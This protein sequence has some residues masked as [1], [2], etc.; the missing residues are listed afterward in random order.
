M[1]R[2]LRSQLGV[3]VAAALGLLTAI[4]ALSVMYQQWQGDELELSDDVAL[5]SFLL[6][7]ADSTDQQPVAIESDAQFALFFDENG[8]VLNTFGDVDGELELVLLDEVWSFTNV[9]DT[10]VGLEFDDEEGSW[11][12]S[13]VQCVDA[14]VCDTA[15]V[16]ARRAA[17]LAFWTKRLAWFILPVLAAIT[18]G[19][20][21]TRWLVGRSLKPVESMRQELDLI[22]ESDLERRVP[23]PQTTDEL[24]RLGS[25]MNQ[26][27]DR[28]ASS[29]DANQRFVA[30]AAHEL[31]SPITGVKAALEIEA[32][33][34]VRPD[35]DAEPSLLDDSVNELD[36]ASRLIDDLLVLAKRQGGAP[37]RTD[38]DLDDLVRA[39]VNM[40]EARHDGLTITKHIQPSRISADADAI[41]RIITN[42]LENAARYGDGTIDVSLDTD[43]QAGVVRLTVD[44]NGPGI[45]PEQQ[46]LIFERFA[47]LDDSRSRATGGA[48]LGLAIAREL[49]EQHQGTI[50]VGSSSLGGARFAVELPA[51]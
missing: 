10:A 51:A 34:Q 30:D 25:S 5:A 39:A 28:L 6:S 46:A 45:A 9:E 48:G 15:I 2:S 37:A 38:V 40:V 22:T 19:W 17:F 13:G 27:I 50:T 18:I 14:S 44:D 4:A 29:L 43:A 1:S 7:E 16:G 35:G 21:A 32:S 20:F 33:K 8:D 26:T 41:N 36:R 24:G 23:V 3:P 42:L 49:A 47:R 11:V 12:V 31:R